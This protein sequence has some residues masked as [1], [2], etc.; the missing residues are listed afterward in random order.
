[1]GQESHKVAVF[2]HSGDYD[3]L[4]EGLSIAASAAACARHV[5]VFLSWWALER[6]AHGKLEAPEFR[7]PRE[8]VTDRF[9]ARRL[10]TLKAL[11]EH[12]RRSEGCT[13]YACTGSMEMLGLRKEALERWVDQFVGWT[14]ILKL[15]E[16]VSDRFWL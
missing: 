9:E 1:M 8:D 16:G 7:P 6:V 15:T 13:V 10:P 3:R 4:H 14:T 2:L 11:L 12:V 5:D